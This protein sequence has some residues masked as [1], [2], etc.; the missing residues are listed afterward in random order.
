MATNPLYDPGNS[1]QNSSKGAMIQ[2]NM[3]AWVA[4]GLHDSG[5]QVVGCIEGVLQNRRLMRKI[6]IAWSSDHTSS[7]LKYKFGIRQHLN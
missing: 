7:S 5:I 3:Y 1:G 6:S 4:E 2:A